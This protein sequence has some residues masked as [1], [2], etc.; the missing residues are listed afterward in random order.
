VRHPIY[1]GFV[2][3]FWATPQMKAGHFDESARGPRNH[4]AGA[5]GNQ[6]ERS[7][8]RLL[9]LRRTVHEAL[10]KL[11]FQV[12]AIGTVVERP[13]LDRETK[14]IVGNVDTSPR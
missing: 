2:L 5:R 1:L 4:D 12:T 7:A 14:L 13:L 3:A 6:V 9:S 11:V 8:N 10:R